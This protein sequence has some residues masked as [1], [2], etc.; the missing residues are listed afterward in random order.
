MR[1]LQ[2]IGL[3]VLALIFILSC[4]PGKQQENRPPNVIVL[5]ADDMG[6]GDL[7]CYGHPTI[8]TPNLDRMAAEGIRLTSFYMGA[9]ICTPSRA[10]LLTGRYP[11]RTGLPNVLLPESNHGLPVDEITLGEALKE[12]GY[13]TMYIGK[14]HLGDREQYHPLRHGF[15]DYYGLLY[16]NDMMPPWVDTQKPLALFHGYEEMEYPVQQQ[17]LTERYT[18]WGMDFIRQ[19]KDG[20]FLLYLAYSMPH[21]PIFASERFTGTSRAGLYGDVVETIDWSVG[22][23]LAQLREL[24]IDD[25]TLVVFTSDNGPWQNMP[26]RMFSNDTIQPWHCGSSGPL[27]G[28]KGD[29]YEGGSRVPAIFRWPGTIPGGQV[30]AD[31]ATAMDLFPTLLNA[32]GAP[33]PEDRVLDGH[34]MLPFLQGEAPSPTGTYLYYLRWELQGIRVGSWK[35]RMVPSASGQAS[36][37]LYELE[38]D[39]GEQFNRIGEQPTKAAELKAHMIQEDEKLRRSIP[40]SETY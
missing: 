24:G 2:N 36:E 39:P 8:R 33:L 15:D 20:P 4:Q 26:Q 22:Q 18:T 35:Y 12:A 31:M 1:N 27:R 11:L 32:A 29:T 16:S 40:H 38:S 19:H 6:Y 9:S 28:S 21:V 13:R 10:A 17:T 30:S 25:R 14:W 37:E 7:G 34:D 3:A 5:L 23:L